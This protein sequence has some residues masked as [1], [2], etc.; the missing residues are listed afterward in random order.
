[1]RALLFALALLVPSCSLSI[2]TD[3]L[4]GGTP[5]KPDTGPCDKK[6]CRPVGK[7]VPLSSIAPC[8]TETTD[9]VG[10]RKVVHDTCVALDSCCFE[11]GIGPVDFPNATDATIICTSGETYS[12][13][14]AEI[15][16]CTP[17][18]LATRECD[19]AVHES[20]PKRGLASAYFQTF[21]GTNLTLI[22]YTTA[23]V[24]YEE[25]V[26]WSELADQNP[27]CSPSTPTSQACT[28]AVHRYCATDGT[29]VSGYGPL[30]WNT[31]DVN[32]ACVF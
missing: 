30:T 21:D 23:Q 5:K 6:A 11:G 18:N 1:M 28:T 25:A 7:V 9:L 2:D 13:P 3:D 27:K 24:F 4:A 32:L 16:K 29:D 8:T 17:A 19:A 26:P 12:V 15:P 20:A 10:C 14:I 22:G 31:T